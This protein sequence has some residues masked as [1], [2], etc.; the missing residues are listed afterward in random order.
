MGIG[1]NI[2][3][4]RML[5]N[6]T[7][8][9]VANLGGISAKWL[10][11]IENELEEISDEHIISISKALEVSVEEL[12]HFHEKPIFNNCNH[13]VNSGY[14]HIVN[15]NCDNK[16]TE[17]YKKIIEEKDTLIKDLQQQVKSA[18]IK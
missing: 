13:S 8:D 18:A 14:N 1:N 6:L 15:Y 16:I 5:K 3:T 9:H 2:R 12:Q 11:K 17:F 7:Q 4:I 10:G